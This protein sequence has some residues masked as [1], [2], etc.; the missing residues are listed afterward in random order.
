MVLM[1]WRFIGGLFLATALVG[2]G[3]STSSSSA[4]T[5]TAADNEPTP[6]PVAAIQQT[7]GEL[8]S[9]A[10]PAELVE[11]SPEWLLQKIQQ[12]RMLP[13]PGVGDEDSDTTSEAAAKALS[14]KLAAA[15]L[16]R[17]ERNQEIVKLA[18]EALTL[19]A[20]DPQ[21]E[22]VFLASVSHLLDA[23]LQ[24]ALQGDEESVTALYDWADAFHQ[25]KPDSPAAAESQLTLVNLAHAHTMRYGSTEP[26]WLKEFARQAQLFATRFPADQS[27]TLPLLMAAGRTCELNNLADEAR[28]CYSLIVTR[29]AEAPQAR[30]CEGILRRLSLVGQPLQFAG[31]TLDGS[32]LTLES[33]AGKAVVIIFWASHVKAFHDQVGQVQS[34]CDKYKKYTN[35]ISV[36]LD[37]EESEVDSFLEQTKL[38]WP[39]I[40]H[41]EPDKRGWNAPLAAHYGISVLPT[42]W[43]V[44]P[45]G[46]VSATQVTSETLEEQLREVLLKHFSPGGNRAA[47]ASP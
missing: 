5:S 8:E 29:F 30:Q 45:H 1:H 38:T 47:N 4:P 19:T 26:Q 39:V 16:L 41:V 7:G 10:A 27:R 35:V 11:G 20:K 21:Q 33:Q 24:L 43:I 15:R 25:R 13:L 9:V 22:P 23:R 2:C 44:D 37:S 14:E 17:R 28:S 42:I 40:F 32:F 31:P 46:K 3:Q 34:V 6:L 12:I 36:S 18:T